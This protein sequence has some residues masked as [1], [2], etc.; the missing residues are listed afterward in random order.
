MQPT[1]LPRHLAVI[2]DGNGRWAQARGLTRS[3][4]HAAGTSAARAFV[5]RC[6]ELGIAHVTLYAFS[7][8]NWA[9][10]KDEV[11]SL[12]ELMRRFLDKELDTLLAQDIRLNVLGDVDALPLLTRKA[13]AHT[14]A[15]TARGRSMILNLA[16]NYS[17]R[18]E[19]V[20]A[21]RLLAQDGL[22]PAEITEQALA[23]RL[24]TAGQP[25]P[26]LIIRTSGELRL[27]NYL[28]FQCAYSELY[29][30][31]TLWPDFDAAELD[32]A[33]AEYASRKRRFGKTAEQI[34]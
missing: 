1:E 31:P 15:R 5:A 3:Q 22:A 6:R 7:R 27:S 34:E 17:G 23:Q 14:V 13:L 16:L 25:D 33:L 30:T 29:F 4:G 12:F 9:R 32:K 24:Y 2:M 8:E 10:P 19:I 21:A 11:D 18:D 26:D 28:L 20:R